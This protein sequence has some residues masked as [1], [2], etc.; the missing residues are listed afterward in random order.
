MKL[1]EPIRPAGVGKGQVAFEVGNKP[2]ILTLNESTTN[3]SDSTEST[4]ANRISSIVESTKLARTIA[5]SAAS[6]AVANNHNEVFGTK[7]LRNFTVPHAALSTY[8]QAAI[9]WAQTSPANTGGLWNPIAFVD[10]NDGTIIKV[11]RPGWYLVNAW[12]Y[13]GDYKTSQKYDM[14]I[15][16][17][18]SPEMNIVGKD[19][20]HVNDYPTLRLQALVP[21]PGYDYYG[22]AKGPA[23][24]GGFS[25]Y[26]GIYGNNNEV[27]ITAA[28]SDAWLQITWLKP[29][30]SGEAY[31]F[32]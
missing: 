4:E 30:E 21:V 15:Y 2:N 28:N 19:I 8:N 22:N 6:S 20:V 27:N 10:H 17:A 9:K 24:A 32:A 12:F 11:N 18:D 7:G 31:N 3:N 5:Y 14:G 13:C 23:S 16:A 26:F 25:V 29:W 1:N